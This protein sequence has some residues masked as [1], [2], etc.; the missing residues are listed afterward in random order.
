MPYQPIPRFILARPTSYRLLA[1]NIRCCV[2]FPS[3]SPPP[4]P[5]PP[6]RSYLSSQHSKPSGSRWQKPQHPLSRKQKQ[7][8]DSYSL[9]SGQMRVSTKS[10][11]QSQSQSQRRG[12]KMQRSPKNSRIQSNWVSTVGMIRKRKSQRRDPGRDS[13]SSAYGSFW[14]LEFCSQ[15]SFWSFWT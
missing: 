5:P 3:S 12:L 1:Y 6:P 13:R 4:P 14:E 2:P 11:R 15:E 7:A 10:K 9:K 8:Y